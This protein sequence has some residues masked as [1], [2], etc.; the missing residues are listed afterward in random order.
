MGDG[1]GS[2][3]MV[4]ILLCTYSMQYDQRLSE[5][6]AGEPLPPPK[7][8]WVP[9]LILLVTVAST[10]NGGLRALNLASLCVSGGDQLQ[11]IT[12]SE[13][14]KYGVLH[15]EMGRVR[16]QARKDWGRKMHGGERRKK[17]GGENDGSTEGA[18][19]RH[20]RF[21]SSFPTLGLVTS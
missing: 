17:G 9:Y 6:A 8:L 21:R 15:E 5:S 14:G 3:W 13:E 19:R 18:T 12:T 7:F 4:S 2:M 10:C 16:A 20:D 1:V 11:S